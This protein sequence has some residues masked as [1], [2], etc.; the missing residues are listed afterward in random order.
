VS[1]NFGA[2]AK[3]SPPNPHP[4]SAIST[5]CDIAFTPHSLASTDRLLRQSSF[6]ASRQHM[7]GT[8]MPSPCQQDSEDYAGSVLIH[9][10]ALIFPTM[11]MSG[12]KTGWRAPAA[13]RISSLAVQRLTRPR[14]VHSCILRAF[15]AVQVVKR[16]LVEVCKAGWSQAFR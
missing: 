15:G 6:L 14:V 10:M 5:F 7:Q 3:S 8:E 1:G 13:C 2:S 16:S 12:P 11:S 9:N 4:M